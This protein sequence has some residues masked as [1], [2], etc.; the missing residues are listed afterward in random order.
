MQYK[1]K[2]FYC[3]LFIGVI[4]TTLF[5]YLY[6]FNSKITFVSDYK[7]YT[8]SSNIEIVKQDYTEDFDREISLSDFLT[9]SIEPYVLDFEKDQSF[10]FFVISNRYNETEGNK[11]FL[12]KDASIMPN[13]PIQLDVDIED[14]VGQETYDNEQIVI[15]RAKD[16]N[17]INQTLFYGINK[18]GDVISSFTKV[19]GETFS[20]DTLFGDIDEDGLNEFVIHSNY[21]VFV[22]EDDFTLKENWP[23]ETNET[24]FSEIVVEDVNLDGR[25]DIV[26]LT[27]QGLIFVWDWNGTL[28]S[29]FTKRIDLLYYK[30][31]EGFR[32]MPIV[33][34]SN[35]DG[36]VEIFASS[37]FGYLYCLELSKAKTSTYYQKLPNAIYSLNQAT[38]SDIN[39]DG[40]IDII[41]PFSDGFYIF[42]FNKSLEVKTKVEGS[43]SFTGAPVLADINKDNTLELI[44]VSDYRLLVFNYT[45]VENQNYERSIPYAYSNGISPIVFDS[46]SDSEIEIVYLNNYG[47]IKI[48]ETNDFGLLPW[49]FKYS[50]PL[51]SVNNDYDSDGLL[52]YEEEI[53]GS[54]PL[55][56]DSDSDT[57]YDGEEVNQYVMNPIIADLSL[58][59]DED[60][61][62]NIEEV[63][64]YLTNPLNPDSDFDGLKDGEEVLIYSTNP[65]SIDSDEDGLP[66]SFEVEY[67][68]LDP[69]DAD[70]AQLDYD[71][72]NL[73]NLEEYLYGT[74]PSN[75]D[76]D[77]DTLSDGDEIYRY[78]TNPIVPDADADYDGDGLTNV[79]EVD[80][81]HT[82][83]SSADSDGDGIN[84]GEE[85]EKGSDPNDPQSIPK[86]SKIHF[87]TFFMVISLF[88]LIFVITLVKRA[89]N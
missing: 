50:S 84:D 87:D 67:T 3:L 58:D 35:K 70:D 68:F 30:N 27:E 77:S 11:L 42:N 88:S 49:L 85:I 25:K 61:L 37:T 15:V 19:V 75:P 12:L 41:Q 10:E 86:T 64:I 52:N 26:T 62:T 43:Y 8:Y 54:D 76:T 73:S 22:Y 51:H 14:V 6:P 78:F 69:N 4:F 44:F 1:K 13:W 45:G 53:V 16:K 36:V 66:D 47:K 5:L 56:S 23:K 55:N 89:R 31:G 72:D 39:K 46:D 40:L 34:D 59:S 80:I 33:T 83:P 20:G 82:D 79:E 28:L 9:Y 29:H 2:T 63:D 60:N 18:N 65:L 21:Q 17:S 57:V 7:D 71:G 32:V 24:I 81:Y 48:F 74:D 38:A